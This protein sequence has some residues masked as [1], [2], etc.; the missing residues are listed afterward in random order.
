MVMRDEF[1]L[2][3]YDKVTSLGMHIRFDVGVTCYVSVFVVLNAESV[4]NR[5]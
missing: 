2:V 4:N 5:N 3:I 1:N